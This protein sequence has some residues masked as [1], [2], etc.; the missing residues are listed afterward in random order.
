MKNSKY[1]IFVKNDFPNKS[2]IYNSKTGSLVDLDIEAESFFLRFEKNNKMDIPFKY[3]DTML[4]TGIIIDDELNELD[5]LSLLRRR[6][7]FSN[8]YLGMTIA[9][10]LDCNFRCIYCYEKNALDNLMMSTETQESIVKFV[11]D[12]IKTISGFQVTWYGGEPLLA[13]DVINNLSEKFIKICKDN[14][15]HYSAGIITNGYLLDKKIAKELK[16]DKVNFAQITLDGIKEI[17]DKR[18]FTKEH[19]PTF[20]RILKNIDIATAYI[21]RISI[22]V[23]VDK[24]NST[25]I[26]ILIQELESRGI[27]K[28]ALPYLGYVDDI[29]DCYSSKLCM[30]YNDYSKIKFDLEEVLV[31]KGF[32]NT[33]LSYY[34]R[35]ITNVCG[36]ECDYS[37]IIDPDGDFY[38]CWNDIGNKE[39]SVGSFN[40]KENLGN[41]N[42]N[43]IFEYML[44][45][46]TKDS[47]CK[48]CNLLPICMGG[49]PKQRLENKSRCTYLKHTL[50]RYLNAVANEKQN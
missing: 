44:F 25:G 8:N 12:K 24:K 2:L 45:D 43:L 6:S 9:P 15:V 17:H 1:N 39:L 26:P 7:Q 3:Y 46:P 31:Q 42:A 30:S 29:N 32:N 27:L 47:K 5:E 36:A 13:M 21:E 28:K 16:S 48:E 50:D 19:Q 35:Q 40:L 20:E 18:R 22:R 49:C 10:T 33:F 11:E 41:K 4:K 23:N 38:K 34:P 37:F 14:E